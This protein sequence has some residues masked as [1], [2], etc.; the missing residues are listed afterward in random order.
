MVHTALFRFVQSLVMPFTR[1]L[2]FNW[3]Q[4]GW[5]Y[6]DYDY[7]QLGRCPE[8]APENSAF[9]LFSPAIVYYD[10]YWQAQHNA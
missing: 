3:V 1:N 5:Y 10:L 8:A 7:H 6:L 9:G 2:C 4:H